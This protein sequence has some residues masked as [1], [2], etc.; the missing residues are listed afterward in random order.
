MFTRLFLFL[1]Q[2]DAE[3]EIQPDERGEP[4]HHFRAHPHACTQPG[5][6]DSSERRPL[7]ETGGGGA[8]QK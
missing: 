7:P 6:H 5:R 1:L 3:R 2:G 4:R 8:D